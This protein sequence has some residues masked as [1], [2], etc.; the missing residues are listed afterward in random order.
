MA[1][2]SRKARAATKT[3]WRTRPLDDEFGEAL[4]AELLTWP[5]LTLRPMM[6][7]LSYFRGR[8]FLGCYVNRALTNS[9]RDWV[10]RED[11]PAYACIR[12]RA[13]DAARALKQPQ[14]RRAR[15]Q[16]AG[17]VEV[18]LG[19]RELLARA[20][21]WFARAYE[22]PLPPAKKKSAKTSRARSSA[23]SRRKSRR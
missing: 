21:R 17:W 1:T 18:P 9:R 10:N 8:T 14:I 16:F 12:L 2:S 15:L 7:T 3:D 19:S 22:N 23:K 4:R 5:G 6:G 11:E 13:D 20:V